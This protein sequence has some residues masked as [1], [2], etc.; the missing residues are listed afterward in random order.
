[1]AAALKGRPT[2]KELLTATN[3]DMV[4]RDNVF[5]MDTRTADLQTA[6]E[7]RGTYRLSGEGLDSEGTRTCTAPSGTTSEAYRAEQFTVDRNGLLR[8]MVRTASGSR[9]I[10]LGACWNGRLSFARSPNWSYHAEATGGSA[11]A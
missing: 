2:S 10:F 11:G 6:C 3:I 4:V 9:S 5:R 7:Y 1:M 8:S